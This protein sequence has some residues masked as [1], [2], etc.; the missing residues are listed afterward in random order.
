M[1]RLP[2]LLLV[3]ALSLPWSPFA[4]AEPPRAA[5]KAPEAWHV[6][7]WDWATY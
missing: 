4:G 2:A 7:S 3:A 6:S 5:A 1:K